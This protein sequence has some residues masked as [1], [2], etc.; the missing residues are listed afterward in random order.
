MLLAKE[1]R[2][3]VVEEHGAVGRP[4]QCA[5]L[6]SPRTIDAV[7]KRSALQQIRDFKLHSPGGT[8]L[9]LHSKDV[10]GVV[11]DRSEFDLSLA[12]RASDL[13]AEI[14][15][16][17]K[18]TDLKES[19]GSVTLSCKS[20]QRRREIESLILV[21]ADGPRSVV[22]GKVTKK[23]FDILYRGA[24]FEGRDASSGD[25]TV[26][27]WLGNKIAPG[28]FAW[29]IPTGDTVRVGLCTNSGSPPMPLLK[30]FAKKD[31]PEL[32]IED[33]QSGL[34]PVGPVG[35]LSKDRLALLGDAG[36]QTKPITG[37]GVFLGKRAAEI[38]AES[39]GKDGASPEAFS[40][41]ERLY[42]DEFNSQLSR[43]WL[44]RKTINRLSDKKMDKVIEIFSDRPVVRI[45]ERSGDIDNPAGM[46]SEILLKAPRLLQFAPVVLR[47]LGYR[48]RIKE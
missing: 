1:R 8:V 15:Y 4:V 5:G 44:I 34:I 33:K 46:A 19:V 38:L 3:V 13:G 22:R 27:M 40:R 25:G 6:V 29:K 10:G 37:G 23:R 24:Q 17:A 39:I 14:L 42:G 35:K 32:R 30:A 9:E 36:G 31:F 20:D 28:F 47:S 2:V 26:E 21:G 48:D 45:L 16:G 43:A 11:I 7:T 12:G 41:Y 18:A